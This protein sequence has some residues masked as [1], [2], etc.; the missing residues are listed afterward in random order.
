MYRKFEI[1]LSN[2]NI[3]FIIY[4]KNLAKDL[5]LLETDDLDYIFKK[6]EEFIDILIKIADEKR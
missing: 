4:S 2:D 3:S 6:R 5:E 1:D